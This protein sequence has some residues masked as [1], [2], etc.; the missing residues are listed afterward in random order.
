[1]KAALKKLSEVCYA[2]LGEACGEDWGAIK[3]SEKITTW[4][5]KQG[6]AD[7]WSLHV[8]GKCVLSAA[9]DKQ[10]LVLTAALPSHVKIRGK[11]LAGE[12][13]KQVLAPS[14]S[15]QFPCRVQ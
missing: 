8:G 14:I 5:P 12:Y 2:A 11:G 13:F 1:M 6:Q 10:E 7:G 3:E 4:W 15:P 9:V